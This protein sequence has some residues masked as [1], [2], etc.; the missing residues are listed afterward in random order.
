M[1]IGMDILTIEKEDD[2]QMEMFHFK[3]PNTFFK[4]L[5]KN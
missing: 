2:P 3:M 4:L 5:E 1:E